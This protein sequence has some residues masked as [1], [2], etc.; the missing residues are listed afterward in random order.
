MFYKQQLIEFEALDDEHDGGRSG[1]PDQL[2]R[3]IQSF[4]QQPEASLP[5]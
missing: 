2:L 5:L 4:D 1:S 3:Y